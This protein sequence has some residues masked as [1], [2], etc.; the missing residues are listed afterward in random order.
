VKI[1]EGGSEDGVV[2]WIT[3]SMWASL[4]LSNSCSAN[5]GRIAR[6]RSSDIRKATEYLEDNEKSTYCEI[7]GNGKSIGGDG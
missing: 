2:M 3:D 4:S 7:C 6:Y 1:A 5:Y